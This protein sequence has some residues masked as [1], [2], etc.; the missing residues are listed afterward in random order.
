MLIHLH[1]HSS[2]SL[3]KERGGKEKGKK[4]RE[5]ENNKGGDEQ[6]YM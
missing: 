3:I 1:L 5:K 6:R 4:E 2:L